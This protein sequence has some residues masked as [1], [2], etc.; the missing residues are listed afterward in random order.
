MLSDIRGSRYSGDMAAAAERERAKL[1]LGSLDRYAR[2]AHP[3]EQAQSAAA[4]CLVAS[5]DP[6][7]SSTRHIPLP[8][9]VIGSRAGRCQQGEAPT[10]GL[11]ATLSTRQ[12]PGSGPRG[13]SA[14]P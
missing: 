4:L 2:R 14:L 3:V 10:N 7:R 8:Y 11:L 1:W 13:P 12:L 6:L 9:S 5:G